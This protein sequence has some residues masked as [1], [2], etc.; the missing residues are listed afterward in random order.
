MDIEGDFDGDPVEVLFHDK[1]LLIL[2]AVYA[3]VLLAI[4]Y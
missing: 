4:I 1:P 3:V 2:C